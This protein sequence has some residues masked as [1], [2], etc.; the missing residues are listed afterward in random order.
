MGVTVVDWIEDSAATYKVLV[1]WV[2]ARGLSLLAGSWVFASLISSFGFVKWRETI[3]MDMGCS[4]KMMEGKMDLANYCSDLTNWTKVAW[5]ML[6][7]AN[8]EK[9][10]G[11]A[12]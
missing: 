3:E 4:T 1:V 12:M 9:V 6:V 5:R 10:V 11:Y 7:V 8:K 2:E